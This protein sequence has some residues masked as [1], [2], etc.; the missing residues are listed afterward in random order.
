MG[1][2][3]RVGAIMFFSGL[4]LLY[5]LNFKWPWSAQGAEAVKVRTAYEVAL[6]RMGATSE[7]AR[8]SARQACQARTDLRVEKIKELNAKDLLTENE[9][10]EMRAVKNSL[11][12]EDCFFIQPE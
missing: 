7:L 6:E 8:V 10:I 11:L 4:L 1:K 9:V 5:V 2:V 12:S 3:V